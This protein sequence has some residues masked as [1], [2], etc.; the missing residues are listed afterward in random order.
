MIKVTQDLKDTLKH[1][2]N[3]ENVYFDREGNHFLS[4][5]KHKDTGKLYHRIKDLTGK[6]TE[7]NAQGVATSKDV[8]IYEANEAHEIVD[9]LSRGDVF[10]TPIADVVNFKDK[11][12]QSVFERQAQELD[13]L[14]KQ[15]AEISKSKVSPKA[16]AEAEAM[17]AEIA[18]LKEENETYQQMLDESKEEKPADKEVK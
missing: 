12:S 5:H 6:R 13:E 4:V 16:N 8:R 11:E 18:K 1:Y 14:K 7:A 3:I 17:K 15:L 10:S 9:I 2:P